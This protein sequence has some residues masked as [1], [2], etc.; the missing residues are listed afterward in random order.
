MKP[1]NS[2]TILTQGQIT[3]TTHTASSQT[4]LLIVTNTIV[5]KTKNVDPKFKRD[6]ITKTKKIM[7]ANPCTPQ[8]QE[9]Q[10]NNKTKD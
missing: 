7:T 2:T 4:D 8:K 5:T 1:G 10:Y 9:N 6:I 3:I